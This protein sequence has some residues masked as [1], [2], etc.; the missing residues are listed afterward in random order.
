MN[1]PEF[2]GIALA[3]G[4]NIP[5]VIAPDADEMEREAEKI[6]EMTK[7]TGFPAETEDMPIKTGETTPPKIDTK[8][9]FPAEF[10]QKTTKY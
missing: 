8:E 5:G 7:P 9:S 2:R 1:T 4:L 10:E 3:F 6:R